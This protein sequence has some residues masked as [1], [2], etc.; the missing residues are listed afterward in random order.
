MLFEVNHPKRR[1]HEKFGHYIHQIFQIYILEF[2]L[3]RKPLPPS[4][5][6]RHIPL[7]TSHAKPLVDERRGHAYISNTVRSS[8]YTIWDFLPK[9]LIFQATRLSNFYFICIGVPQT[10]PGISTTGNYTTILPLLF[11]IL[12]TVLKEGYDDYRRHRLDQVENKSLATVLRDNHGSHAVSA[13]QSL[14]YLRHLPWLRRKTLEVV[15][16]LGTY[17]PLHWRKIQWRDIKVG[18]II[19]IERDEDIPADVVLLYTAGENGL[20]YIETMA[21]D[22]ET[23]LK[24]RQALSALKTCSDLAEITSTVAEFVV[25]DPNPDLYSFHGK[26][27][28]GKETLPLTLNEVI[29]RGCILRNTGFIIG[30]VINTGEECKIRMNANQHPNAKKPRLEHFAN[31]AVLTLIVYVILL[32]GGLS[33][34]YYLWQNSTE[35]NSF[36]IAKAP[37]GYQQIIIGYAIMF[38]NVIPLALYVSL[39]I[40]KIGQMLMVNADIEMY[41]EASDTPMRC[42]TNTILENLGQVDYLFSDKTGTLTENV[43]RFRKMTFAGTAWSHEVEEAN[44]G[45]H[46]LEYAEKL[47]GSRDGP[48]ITVT[49]F[50]EQPNAETALSAIRRSL[51][52][53]PPTVRSVAPTNGSTAELLQLIKQHPLSLFTQRTR[54]FILGLALCHTCLPEITEDVIGFQASSPDE[55]ALV[56][57]AQDMGYLVED[58]SSRSITLRLSTGNGNDIRQVYEI[59]D[60][61]EFSSKRKRMSIIVRCPDRRILVI[62]KG[63]DNMLLPRLK[64][65]SLAAQQASDVRKSVELER[66]LYRKSAE[67]QARNSIGARLSFDLRRGQSMKRSPTTGTAFEDPLAMD[68]ASIFKRC[69]EDIDRYATEGLRTLLFT[70]RYIETQ[71]YEAWKKVYEDATTS[72]TNRQERIEAAGDLIEQSLDLLG[73]TAIEDKLQHGVPETVEKL[74]Q[75]NIKIWMLTGDKRETAISIAHSARICRPDSDLFILDIAKG[76]LEAQMRVIAEDLEAGSTHTVAVI[77][78]NTLASVEEN[79]YLKHLFY[80]LITYINSVICCR[81]SPAQKASMVKGIRNHVVGALTLAIGDGSND[82]A[83]IQASH[84]GVGISGKEGLQ[85]YRAADYSIAQFRFLQRLLLVHGRWNYFRTAQFIRLTFWKEMFFYMP[86]ALYQR[87]TGY[88]GTSLYESWSLTVLNTLF[89]SLCVI[90]PG[91][92][93][94]DLKADTLLAVPELYRYGQLNKALNIRR[95][96]VWMIGATATGIVVWFICWAAF[97]VYDIE[98]GQDL[99]ALGDLVFTVAIVWTNCKLFLIETHYKTAVVLISFLITFAGWWAWNIFLACAYDSENRWPYDVRDGFTQHFGKDPSW[100]LGLILAVALL[101]IGELAY[102]QC[103]KSGKRALTRLLRSRPKRNEEEKD[104]ANELDVKVWQELEKDPVIRE[105]LRQMANQGVTEDDIMVDES[106]K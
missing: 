66:Q 53:R 63:A 50:E 18:D 94:Q 31:Q 71:E 10:I 35:Q 97:G 72:L 43:M 92:F 65:A 11:F 40:V 54:A 77:D 51:S 46:S 52:T 82:I 100:W 27:T 28:V 45:K 12:L 87:Y 24:N 99:F 105:R 89:T 81:A 42:N 88:T 23:N 61:I 22:G 74:R 95:Y 29:L 64:Q 5:D 25:E 67:E 47:H 49:E 68:D 73:V 36:Y 84:V 101:F 6:G 15:S 78:G 62:C 98:G 3:R 38:N 103:A 48:A 69:F 19:R 93:D 102:R 33:I 96:I 76:D 55:L 9:Q 41:D 90:V 91:I 1:L 14:R 83:M 34:G 17:G 57:A 13:T 20:A 79:P 7:R 26:V 2:V 8:R 80:S 70:H 37:V 106:I 21:L 32:S 59:L 16:A 58:R 85:A 75:A 39:E 86:Q 44:E 4:K 30:M 60:V 104:M 56:R